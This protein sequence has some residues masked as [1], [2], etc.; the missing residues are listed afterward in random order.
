TGDLAF[1]YDAN[2]LWHQ[3]LPSSFRVIVINNGGG[4]IFRFIPGPSDTAE[5]EPFFEARGG[6]RCS[7]IAETFGL[8]YFAAGNED[9]LDQILHR[10]WDEK[11]APVLLEIFTPTE[12]NGEIL[13]D[14]FRFL[15]RGWKD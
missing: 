15:G 12:E 5:L 14:Y 13:K 6:Q 7:G 2:G 3:Y 11:G 9:E 1:L 8:Q 10:F 4:G